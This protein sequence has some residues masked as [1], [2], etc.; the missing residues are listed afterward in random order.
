[1][2]TVVQIV[3]VTPKTLHLF[4]N[5]RN[6]PENAIGRILN[7]AWDIKNASPSNQITSV[8]LSLASHQ[9]TQ[10]NH[11]GGKPFGDTNLMVAHVAMPGQ[12]HMGP[13][14]QTTTLCIK[15]N[16][17][18]PHPFTGRAGGTKQSRSFVSRCLTTPEQLRQSWQTHC[19]HLIKHCMQ[20]NTQTQHA[21][22]EHCWQARRVSFRW[23]G[24]PGAQLSLAS[25]Q[26][27]QPNHKGGI[28]MAWLP[29]KHPKLE[30]RR[31]DIATCPKA[32]PK[33]WPTTHHLA[34]MPASARS[35]RFPCFKPEHNIY[36]TVSCLM[37][38]TPRTRSKLSTQVK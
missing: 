22:E 38:P 20:A 6:D 4:C 12:G 34:P 26:A 10:P 25:H 7:R 24:P 29:K 3:V 21:G 23:Q 14:N 9:A 1:M 33:P 35:A 15:F 36:C 32:K 8:E 17:H 30:K 11:K 27:T 31:Q 16:H 2:A 5:K 13:R 19:N 18:I 28:Q 37:V